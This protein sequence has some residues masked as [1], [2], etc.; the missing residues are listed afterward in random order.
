MSKVGKY[1]EDHKKPLVMEDIDTT[2]SKHGMKYGNK[3]RNRHASIFAYRKMESCIENQ[4]Y[5]RNFGVI[6]V[7]PA[8]TSQIGKILYMRKFGI[9]IHESASYVI[10]L[11]GMG[12]RN[13]LMP[14]E[15]MVIRLTDNLKEELAN[16][17]MDSLMKV[18]KYI[19]T[20]LSGIC[21]HSFYRQIPYEYAKGHELSKKQRKPKSLSAIATEM[22]GWTACNY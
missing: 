6:K 20:K 10:G 7:N 11:K 12:L 5:R 17:D 14:E 1:C 3:K 2:I 8:Y 4:S 9:S 22:K 19:S 13:K 16:E 18:W 15:K 21:T